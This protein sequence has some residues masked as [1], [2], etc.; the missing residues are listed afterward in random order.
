MEANNS[1]SELK[2]AYNDYKEKN[3]TF[4]QYATV[5][6]IENAFS[7]GKIFVFTGGYILFKL[8]I[9]LLVIAI[10]M[11]V[12]IGGEYFIL[13]S[14]LFAIIG[15][16]LILFGIL[17]QRMFLVI[18]TTGVYYRRFTKIGYFQ[19]DETTFAK[20]TI[21]RISPHLKPPPVKTAEVNLILSE[22]KKVRFTSMSYQNKEFPK[23]VK[24]QMFIFLFYIY[25][26]LGKGL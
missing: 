18:G 17:M 13:V 3:Y 20:G 8:C 26:D 7:N 23:N 2:K 9:Y 25:S 22:G 11:I 24:R 14:S 6:Q 16:F 12:I 5:D 1:L 21:G 19:W 4:G 15:L 10:S